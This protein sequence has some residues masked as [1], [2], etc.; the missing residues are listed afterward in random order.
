MT[1]SNV[2]FVRRS[3]ST[4][5]SVISAVLALV[6]T[7]LFLT[8][9]PVFLGLAGVLTRPAS[10]DPIA[11]ALARMFLGGVL[12]GGVFILN[13]LDGRFFE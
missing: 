2:G 6:A 4:V 8:S 11:D 3:V 1:D 7:Y 9:L 13:W 12:L 5:I 10:P